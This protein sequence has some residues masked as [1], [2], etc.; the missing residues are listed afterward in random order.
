MAENQTKKIMDMI[1]KMTVLELNDLVKALEDKFGVSAGMPMVMG[2]APAGDAV[3]AEAEEEQDEFD[4]ILTDIG[5]SKIAVIKVVR[6]LN[7]T[8]GLVEAKT[9]VESAPKSILEGVKKSAAAEAKKKLEG[10]GAKV[11][12]K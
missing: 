11:E 4:V 5:S 6:E 7:Q 12:L 1:E 3:I 10:A 2:T 9:L 8:L